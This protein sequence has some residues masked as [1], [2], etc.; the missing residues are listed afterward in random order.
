MHEVEKSLYIEQMTLKSYGAVVRL[1]SLFDA[2]G[3]E[4]VLEVAS[5]K[6]SKIPLDERCDGNVAFVG[7]WWV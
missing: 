3:F 7:G 5:V 1:S 4:G 2:L 6:V